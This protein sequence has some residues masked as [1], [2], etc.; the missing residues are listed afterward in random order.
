MGLTL[1]FEKTLSP[2]LVVPRVIVEGY[3]KPNTKLHFKIYNLFTP[4][5]MKLFGIKTA[6]WFTNLD[7]KM[8]KIFGVYQSITFIIEKD[9][10]CKKEILHKIG[11]EDFTGIK[12]AGY[13]LK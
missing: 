1:E 9:D 13:K 7:I 3:K 2:L 11:A 12:V 10:K 4:L 8:T 6:N 5:F